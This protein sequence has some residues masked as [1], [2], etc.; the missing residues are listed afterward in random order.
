MSEL[1]NNSDAFRERSSLDSPEVEEPKKAKVQK[2][3]DGKIVTK[4]K[5]GLKEITNGFIQEDVGTV[6][7]YL[8][9]D[10]LWPAARKTLYDLGTAAL[11]MFFYGEDGAPKKSGKMDDASWRKYYKVQSSDNSQGESL[12]RNPIYSVGE[13]VYPTKTK[14]EEAFATLAE[15]I[16]IYKTVSVADLYSTV[17]VT[18]AFTDH[19]WGWRSMQGAKIYPTDD[20]WVLRMP[21]AVPL[22]D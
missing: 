15:A 18:G 19:N 12:R 11:S 13:A 9:K 8:W 22:N 2:V 6:R 1:K 20:G 21:K 4:K 10:V 17:G 7:T 14:A 3:T 5:P 16:D